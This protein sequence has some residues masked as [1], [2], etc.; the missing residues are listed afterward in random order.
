MEKTKL[1]VRVDKM[2]LERAKAYAAR[3]STS[4][5]RLISDYLH[6]LGSDE[7][8]GTETPVLKKLT[9]ILPADVTLEE[10]RIHLEDKHGRRD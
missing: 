1:T 3:R 6:L 7:S 5:S 8:P 4:L 2:A 9:G 10:Y